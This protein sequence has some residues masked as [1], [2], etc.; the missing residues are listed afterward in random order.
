MANRAFERCMINNIESWHR[1][2]MNEAELSIEQEDLILVTGW[3]KTTT[4]WHLAAFSEES[5]VRAGSIKGCISSA[6]GTELTFSVSGGQSM[7]FEER[8][9]PSRFTTASSTDNSGNESR[10]QCIFL[11]A[12]RLQ[13]RRFFPDFKIAASA[14]PP[15]LPDGWGYDQ[16]GPSSAVTVST[17]YHNEVYETESVSFSVSDLQSIICDGRG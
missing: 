12:Y 16:D 2:A 17:P 6:V 7:Q 1:F 10:N 11:K 14:G 5:R 3:T 9:G 13:R 15:T 4:S 8:F